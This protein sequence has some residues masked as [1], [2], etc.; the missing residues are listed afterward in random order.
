MEAASK[1]KYWLMIPI[2]PFFL[3]C[4]HFISVIISHRKATKWVFKCFQ[5]K[6]LDI[7]E[8]TA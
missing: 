8:I 2:S 3:L 5:R 7:V 6:E 4:D 1:N